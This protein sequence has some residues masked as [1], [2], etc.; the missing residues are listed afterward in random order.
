M[1]Q[2]V[3]LFVF[4]RSRAFL[5]EVSGGGRGT[6]RCC[7]V[8]MAVV[9]YSAIV[10]FQWKAEGLK[11]K[12]ARFTARVASEVLSS[13]PAVIPRSWL[14]GTVNEVTGTVFATVKTQ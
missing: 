12:N 5:A 13:T 11:P 14:P 10:P 1:L 9:R 6:A 3:R 8:G 2:N 7:Y 4:L